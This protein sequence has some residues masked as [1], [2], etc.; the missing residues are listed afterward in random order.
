MSDWPHRPDPSTPR[1]S[2][3]PPPG[4]SHQQY[5]QQGGPSW[6]APEPPRGPRPPDTGPYPPGRPPGPPAAPPPYGPGGPPPGRGGWQGPADPVPPAPGGGHGGRRPLRSALLVG[7]LVGLVVGAVGFVAVA[8]ADGQEGGHGDGGGSDPS[9]SS[10][11]AGGT[12]GGA[13]GTGSAGPD[14]AEQEATPEEQ[15][16]YDLAAAF[17]AQDC[18]AVVAASNPGYWSDVLQAGEEGEAITACEA[19]FASGELREVTI[20]STT[21]LQGDDRM[22]QVAVESSGWHEDQFWVKNDGGTWMVNGA[23]RG[24]E[25]NPSDQGSDSGGGASNVPSRRPLT[26]PE[27]PPSGDADLDAPA[28]ECQ[29]G[30]MVACDDLYWA[31]PRGSEHEIYGIGCGG[32]RLGVFAGGHCERDFN[33]TLEEGG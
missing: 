4:G 33:R 14:R 5:P 21:I 26:E 31:A 17:A 13:D 24:L 10:D 27:D 28:T 16:V 11:A 2:H 18:A 22:V 19:G 25:G 20:R 1:R 32:R 6:R 23:T 15:A 8:P 9:S 7:A 3:R 12:G 29:G 30:D